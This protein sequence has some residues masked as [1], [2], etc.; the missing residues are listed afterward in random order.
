MT[1]Y[2]VTGAGDLFNGL[3]VEGTV[4]H[5]DDCDLLVVQAVSKMNDRLRQFVIDVPTNSIMF[6]TKALTLVIDDDAEFDTSSPFGKL[7]SD[8]RI[9]HGDTTLTWAHYEDA[10]SMKVAERGTTLCAYNFLSDEEIMAALVLVSN[11]SIETGY[12]WDD[13]VFDVAGIKG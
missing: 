7:I 12:D 13:L 1:K 5:Y 11:L 8:G 3:I 9:E 4:V 2:E 10:M 6:D